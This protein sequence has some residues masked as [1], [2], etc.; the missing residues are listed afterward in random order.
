M[1]LTIRST[2]ATGAIGLAIL[3]CLAAAVQAAPRCTNGRP[4][5]RSLVEAE[6]AFGQKA[7]SSVRGAFLEY[8][9]EDSTVL[10]PAPE[11]GRP[12]YL[13]VKESKNQ[14]GWYPTL[15]EVASGGDLGF[16]EGPYTFTLAESSKQ[17]HGHFLTVWKRDATCAWR[18]EF[19]GGVSHPADS[20][21]EAKLVPYQAPFNKAEPPRR[22][23]WL[24]MPQAMRLENSNGRCS[25]TASPRRCAPMGATLIFCS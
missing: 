22:L 17:F 18:V 15:A 5:L 19:D 9:A 1:R 21:A 20:I 16:T 11:P 23:W 25:R 10:N 12:V 3:A 24:P 8:L 14:L 13:A 2:R 7:Q 6:Y 4:A